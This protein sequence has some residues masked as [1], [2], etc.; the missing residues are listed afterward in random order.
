MQPRHFSIASA[1]SESFVKKDTF[2]IE[3]C[4]A[5]VEGTTPLGRSYHGL[6]SK[7]LANLNEK[8]LVRMW[9]RPGSFGKLPLQLNNEGRFDI[10]ILCIGAGT[11]IAPL[12]S[13]ILEREAI[14][15]EKANGSVGI[16]EV[17]QSPDNLL[18]FGCRKESADFYYGDTWKKLVAEKR[19]LLW[20]AFSRDQWH[21]IY[22]QQ[23]LRGA[24]DGKLVQQH[25]LEHGGAVFIAGGAK[26]AR[27]V[28]EEVLECL[29]NVVGE[30]QSA[31]LMKRLNQQGHYN[32]EAWS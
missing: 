15:K 24:N 19:L 18:I 9:I 7:Y 20:T 2:H 28:K 25:I 4:V 17:N 27:A 31:M 23:V 16:S 8:A 10:P 12:R 3:L 30:K 1:L 6:C 5:V 13:L 11:G 26:M 29:A 21:K 14:Y 22:V 32:V